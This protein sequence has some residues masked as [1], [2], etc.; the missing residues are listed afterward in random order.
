MDRAEIEF[1]LT[2][3]E[4]ILRQ[5]DIHIENLTKQLENLQNKRVT[6]SISLKRDVETM[7]SLRDELQKKNSQLDKLRALYDAVNVQHKSLLAEREREKSRSTTKTYQPDRFIQ[8]AEP[9]EVLREENSQL[10]H[11]L[12]KLEENSRREH[13]ELRR[14]FQTTL[15]DKDDEVRFVFLLTFVFRRISFRLRSF[16]CVK[17]IKTMFKNFSSNF[18]RTKMK[19]V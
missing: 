13:F 19:I 14:D 6:S 7:K 8:S 17:N 10:K 4:E 12:E 2:K 18:Q 5:R 11:L 9:I 16:K 1:K 15:K 3:T